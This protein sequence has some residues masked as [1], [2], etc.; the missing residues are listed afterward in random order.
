MKLEHES[1]EIIDKLVVPQWP[2]YDQQEEQ[3]LLRVLHSRNWW[4]MF[5]EETAAFEKE[6]STHHGAI[7]GLA[8]SNGTH[9]LEIALMVAGIKPGDEVIV[10]AF[11]FISTSMAVQRVGAIP[12]PVDV[13]LE[14][15]CMDPKEVMAAITSSTK[16][17]IPVHMAGHGADMRRLSEIAKL[18][19][20]QIIQDAAHAHGSVIEG[21]KIGEWGSMACFSFQNYKL[22]TAGE[23]GFITFS[24][25]ETRNL[26][27]LYHNCGRPEGDVSYQ[28]KVLGSNY[29]LN[30]FASG[31]LRIQLRRLDQQNSLR[32]KNSQLLD[33]YLQNESR[34]KLQKRKPLATLHSHYMYMF[35]LNEEE[36]C[37]EKRNRMVKKLVDLGVPA[38]MTYKSLYKTQAFWEN[39]HP[40]Y[41]ESY[42]R[43][44]CSNTEL[45]SGNGIWIHHRALLGD[46]ALIK[47]IAGCV[48]EV[49]DDE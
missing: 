45:I 17:M 25:D 28:H 31:L 36:I 22:M 34:I 10:P 37:F 46:E 12:I 18:H 33:Y 41:D 39:P 6:F 35:L 43:A 24:D 48:I 8:V 21:K 42:W 47:D 30:E 38:Y 3:A 23:G 4:R 15:Y 44:R 27:F 26:A 40:N 29:R 14:T 11:T 32:E 19:N 20:I 2:I 7:Q 49:L 5:G 9:A 13:D 16:A 1:D